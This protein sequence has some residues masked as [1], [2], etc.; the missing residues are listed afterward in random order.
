MDLRQIAYVQAI[1]RVSNFTRAAE[2]L[3]VA[4]P[5]LSATIRNLE[6]ELGVRLFERSSRSVSLT[7]A[8]RAFLAGSQRI[9]SE[10]T[11]LQ[12]QMS[13]FAGGLR[14]SVRASCWYHIYPPTLDFLRE[15]TA[16]NPG[17]DLSIVELPSPQALKSVRVGDLDLAVI[18]ITDGLDLSGVELSMGHSEPYVLTVHPDHPLAARDSVGLLDMASERFIVSAPGTAFRRLFDAAFSDVERTPRMVIETNEI[19]AA[20]TYVSLGLGVAMLTPSIVRQIGVPVALVPIRDLRPFVS[21]VVWRPGE[22]GKAVAGA[23]SLA[24]RIAATSRQ[25]SVAAAG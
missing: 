21:A 19:A 12:E 11:L 15:Y 24:S 25:E 8:G 14:G 16:A 9:S 2:E 18:V 1:A 17:V 5:A 20:V 4:Q 6:G 7:D 13:E 3:H 23:I 10:V 22:H